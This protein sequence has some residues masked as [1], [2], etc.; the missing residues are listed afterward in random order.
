MILLKYR[1][2]VGVNEQ[3]SSGLGYGQVMGCYEHGNEPAGC[4]KGREFLD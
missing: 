3:G 2:R 4:V 1:T